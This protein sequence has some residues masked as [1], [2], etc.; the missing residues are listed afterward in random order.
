MWGHS[1]LTYL[2]QTPLNLAEAFV[3]GQVVTNWVLPAGGSI[4]EIGK[5][6][7]NPAVDF[8]NRQRLAGRLLN[9]H[10]DEQRKRERGLRLQRVPL[11]ASAV[12]WGWRGWW[13]LAGAVI[14]LYVKKGAAT[15]L[16]FGAPQGEVLK[17]VLVEP[18]EVGELLILCA[19]S[20][21]HT[22]RQ[23]TGGALRLRQRSH[24]TDAS[25]PRPLLLHTRNFRF[26]IWWHPNDWTH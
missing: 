5:V 25:E 3:Q 24:T 15:G 10:V 2:S 12:R 4:G 6:L 8:F 18:V 22:G 9:G 20:A 14:S 19:S 23:R 13:A 7:K 1:L 11:P 26:L 17:Q 16:S 21:I